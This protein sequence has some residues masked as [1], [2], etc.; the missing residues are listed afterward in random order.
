MEFKRRIRTV[1]KLR[2]KSGTIRRG[3]NAYLCK[4]LE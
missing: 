3:N 4:K 2:K 1:G